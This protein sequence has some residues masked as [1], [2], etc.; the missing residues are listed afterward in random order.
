MRTMS[1]FFSD[2]DEKIAKA[3]QKIRANEAK[4]NNSQLSGAEFFKYK[5]PALT[6]VLQDFVTELT[7]RSI[8]AKCSSS[9]S[10]LGIILRYNKGPSL[11]L[12]CTFAIEASYIVIATTKWD[13]HMLNR[14]TREC[15]IAE[16][17]DDILESELK[18]LVD[19]YMIKAE[20][21]GI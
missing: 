10:F 20:E 21:Y 3:K 2:L 16:W 7:N 4:M 15:P 1:D 14:V 9:E 11:S 13:G 5:I 18:T 6:Q 12:K 17:R 19:S 8:D